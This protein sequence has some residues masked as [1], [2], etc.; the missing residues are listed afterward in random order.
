MGSGKFKPLFIDPVRI[1]L[2]FIPVRTKILYCFIF[3]FFRS[4]R[5]ESVLV[6]KKKKKYSLIHATHAYSRFWERKLTQGVTNQ[7]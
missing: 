7:I 4:L 5:F 3:M 6:K 1:S 2:Y